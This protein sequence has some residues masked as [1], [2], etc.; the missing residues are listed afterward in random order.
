L[1]FGIA[2]AAFVMALF[3]T[4]DWSADGVGALAA[5]AGDGARWLLIASGGR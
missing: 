3:F 1:R 4:P 2:I 5:S